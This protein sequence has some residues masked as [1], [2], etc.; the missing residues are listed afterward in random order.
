MLGL[1]GSSASAI[2]SGVAARLG[3]VVDGLARR[4]LGLLALLVWLVGC[5][6]GAL[7]PE[8]RAE[9][10]WTTYHRDAGRSGDDPDASEGTTPV[11]I[12]HSRDLGAPIWGQPVVLASTAVVATVGDEIYAL[13]TASGNVLW[14]K[15][16]GTPVPS[17]ELPCGDVRPT[18]GIVGTP[19]IDASS[20]IVYAVADTWDAGTKEAHHV[21]KG[22]RLADGE[23]VLSTSVDPPGADPKALLQRPGLNVD[24]GNVVFGMGGNDGDCSDYRGTAVAAPE[25]GGAPRFWQVPIAPPSTTGGAIWGA[26][27]PVVDGEGRIYAATGNPNPP[28][29]QRAETYDYSDS[30][31]ELNSSLNLIGHFEPSSWLADSNADLDLGSAGP[32][33]LPGGRLFQAGK[34]GTGYVIDEAG[35]SSGKPAVYS[36]EVC[37]GHSSFGGDAYATGVIYVACTNGTQA[38]AYNQEAGTFTPLWKGPSD[39]NGPPIVSGGRVW[40]VA[41][42]G[43]GTKLYGLDRHTGTAR[44]TETLPSAVADHFASPS[45]AGGRLFVATGSSVTAYALETLTRELP[46]LGQCLKIHGAATARYKDSGCVSASAGEDSGRF[47]WQPLARTAHHFVAAGGATTLATTG[48]MTV[49]CS[50]N[51]YAGEYSSRHTANAALVLKG[52]RERA[53]AATSCASEGAPVGEIHSGAL[54]GTLGFIRGGS[55]P[56]VGWDL[57]AAAPPLAVM[58][59]RCGEAV[60]SVTGSVIAQ[61]TRVDRMASR[62]KLTYVAAAGEQVPQ[63]FEGGAK[64]TLALVPSL[65]PTEPLG[66]AAK[67]AIANGARLEIKALP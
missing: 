37:G 49:K 21:L 35:L 46:E 10:M 48:G 3:A 54:E 22:Y 6:P 1:G 36:H 38:L 56:A 30:V 44:F 41:T 28:A 61:V 25:T 14:E 59:F 65:G 45:A 8:A 18:V 32:E 9:P 15:S 17:G 67:V 64:D 66:I 4:R 39:A 26:S 55:S 27:G 60:F 23:E 16:A 53:P 57:K 12:W 20:G 62:F 7:A 58:S 47:E 52:C 43:S 42:H 50:R 19:V 11:E 5:L 24:Q 13:N 29:G 63:A 31:V 40:A 2:H 51:A 34:N 33:L